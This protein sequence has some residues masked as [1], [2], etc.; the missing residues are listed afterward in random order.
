MISYLSGPIGVILAGLHVPCVIWK[1]NYSQMLLLL[2]SG[3]VHCNP[4]PDV[5]PCGFCCI[6]VIDFDEAVCD[7]CDKWIYVFYDEGLSSDDY[8]RMVNNPSN[9]VWFCYNCA[10]M[11]SPSARRTK[12]H[13]V[14]RFLSCVCLNARSIMSNRFDF[15][16]YMCT[17]FWY[18]CIHQNFPRWL[19]TWFSYHNTR[20]LDRNR[21]KVYYIII[22]IVRVTI[23]IVVST[24]YLGMISICQILIGPCIVSFT[25]H[26]WCKLALWDPVQLFSFPVGFI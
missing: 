9:D 19:C 17:W 23:V 22:I 18:Y 11:L 8:V 21:L 24:M 15:L 3:D 14:T 20:V 6:L 26:S 13:A 10:T 12:P 16:Y 25:L 5:H 2:L 7:C 1:S 4:G